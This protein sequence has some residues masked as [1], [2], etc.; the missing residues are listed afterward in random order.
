MRLPAADMRLDSALKPVI[1]SGVSGHEGF[2]ISHID[3]WGDS[4]SPDPPHVWPENCSL[5]YYEGGA[6]H[7]GLQMGQWLSVRGRP[8]PVS[9]FLSRLRFVFPRNLQNVL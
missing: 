9:D 5:V 2:Y 3:S 8:C 6:E 1:G 7:T 4:E